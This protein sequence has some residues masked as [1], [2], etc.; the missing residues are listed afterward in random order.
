MW[1][2]VHL[3]FLGPLW[4][5]AKTKKTPVLPSLVIATTMEVEMKRKGLHVRSRSS[6]TMRMLCVD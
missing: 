2:Q 1:E 4:T 5:L 6:S 3:L